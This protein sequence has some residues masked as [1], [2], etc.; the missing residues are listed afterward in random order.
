MRAIRCSVQ[1]YS[2]TCNSTRDVIKGGSKNV[3][4]VRT[5]TV[6]GFPR[7]YSEQ[8]TQSV[9]YESTEKELI[10]EGKVNETLFSTNG[11][12][13]RKCTRN[14]RFTFLVLFSTSSHYFYPRM[15]IR[16]FVRIGCTI[17]LRR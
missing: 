5:V 4:R 13:S 6:T 14:N 17:I 1:Q 16:T 8:Y 12:V 3:V 2:H 15:R 11:I 7:R 9:V 10:E